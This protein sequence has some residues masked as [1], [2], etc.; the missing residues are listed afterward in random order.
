MRVLH[1]CRP[2]KVDST[3]GDP[4]WYKVANPPGA[5]EPLMDT[6]I[7]CD[8]HTETAA[9]CQDETRDLPFAQA[10]SAEDVLELWKYSEHR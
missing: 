3:Q 1:S 10:H 2:L 6:A 4:N 7:L 9:L 8:R 5:P